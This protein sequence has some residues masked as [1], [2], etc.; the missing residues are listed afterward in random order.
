MRGPK[1]QRSRPD[2]NALD[3]SEREGEEEGK[4]EELGGEECVISDEDYDT[5]LE[6]EGIDKVDMKKGDKKLLH[7]MINS[8]MYEKV[9]IWLDDVSHMFEMNHFILLFSA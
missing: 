6:L 4:E 9:R 7:F 5:D 8:M 1:D 3:K 2:G